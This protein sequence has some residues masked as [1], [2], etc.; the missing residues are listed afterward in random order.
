MR[1]KL[2]LY[3]PIFLFGVYLA[4][5]WRVGGGLTEDLCLGEQ[6]LG[7]RDRFTGGSSTG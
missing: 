2:L 6:G 1:W 4:F 3:H 7:K 5:V